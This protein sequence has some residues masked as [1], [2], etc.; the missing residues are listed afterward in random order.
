MAGTPASPGAAQERQRDDVIGARLPER[1]IHQAPPV[2]L[3]E[4]RVDELDCRR[5]HQAADTLAQLAS[6]QRQRPI[7]GCEEAQ[8]HAVDVA[9]GEFTRC[10]QRKLVQRQEPSR[11]GRSNERHAARLATAQTIEH[12]L[13]GLA[14][15]LEPECDRI[16]K[17]RT[18]PR[19]QSEDERVEGKARAIGEAD[20]SIGG[21]YR[22]HRSRARTPRRTRRR[23]PAANGAWPVRG[24]TAPPPSSGGRRTNRPAKRASE[25]RDRRA[26]HAERAAPLG[27]RRRRRR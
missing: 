23:F 26:E 17:R 7:F 6:E 22:R 19:A 24:Q 11:H 14:R 20:P 13:D 8:L 1:A 25:R 12:L 4:R 21:I 27:R 2:D 9:P 18:R 3:R 10:H 5:T 15:T 16:G